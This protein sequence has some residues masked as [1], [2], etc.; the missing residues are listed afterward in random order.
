MPNLN[1]DETSVLLALEHLAT[2]GIEWERHDP[3]DVDALCAFFLDHIPFWLLAM[4][5]AGAGD[6]GNTNRVTFA[7]KGLGSLGFIDEKAVQGP[8]DWLG[9]LPQAPRYR[10][11]RC[12]AGHVVHLSQ[13][14]PDQVLL[15]RPD[16]PDEEGWRLDYSGE[17]RPEMVYAISPSGA[18]AARSLADGV[19]SVDSTTKMHGPPSPR[20]GT[21][22]EADGLGIDFGFQGDEHV[23][24]TPEQLELP[25]LDAL[26]EFRFRGVKCHTDGKWQ[27][28]FRLKGV[29]AP[30][31]RAWLRVLPVELSAALDRLRELGLVESRTSKVALPFAKS[32]T[33]KPARGKGQKDTT[34]ILEKP[35]AGHVHIS[36]V[37]DAQ[38]DTLI[39]M[40]GKCDGE[41]FAI[42]DP[43]PFSFS[44]RPKGGTTHWRLTPEGFGTLSTVE[45][46]P[47]HLRMTS[48]GGR[49]RR[50]LWNRL[51]QTSKRR[52]QR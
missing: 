27:P 33:R 40:S 32:I 39:A 42:D 21:A 11:M 6:V 37:A 8:P 1:P 7:L 2:R 9:S 43:V 19:R 14:A 13:P 4:Y 12:P 26:Y 25:V 10:L 46:T 44:P 41:T 17:L 28:M 22:E 34:A 50:N 36:I 51:S 35:G 24:R 47:R 48:P 15:T 38:V 52:R 16:R 45:R 30:I 29:P 23:Q 49:R 3:D 5:L 18:L 20:D 31:L